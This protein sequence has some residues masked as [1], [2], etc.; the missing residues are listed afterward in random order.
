MNTEY[1]WISQIREKMNKTHSHRTFFFCKYQ[2]KKTIR[3]LSPGA[4][5]HHAYKLSTVMIMHTQPQEIRGLNG[6]D[7][8]LQVHSHYNS[9]PSQEPEI[10]LLC[11][12]VYY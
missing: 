10:E 1:Y 8:D 7:S 3:A 4:N 5:S 12:N 6:L 9:R 2:L 11:Y